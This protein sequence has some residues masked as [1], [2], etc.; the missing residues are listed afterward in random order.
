[1]FC[2]NVVNFVILE[3]SPLWLVPRDFDSG[4]PDTEGECYRG[5]ITS[6]IEVESKMIEH[7]LTDL[8]DW[9]SYVGI[10]GEILRYLEKACQL[11]PEESLTAQCKEMVDNYYP[12]LIGIIKG[13]LV[14]M[15]PWTIVKTQFESWTHPLLSKCVFISSQG[16]SMMSLFKGTESVSK[17]G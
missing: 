1:M 10:Q 4:G 13:E 15:T 2:N 16:F 11:I 17:V 12:I 3:N 6:I 9:R 7:C 5:K 14:S 8:C